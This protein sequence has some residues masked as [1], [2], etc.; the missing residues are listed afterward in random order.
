VATL[1]PAEELIVE[2]MPT[3]SENQ[4]GIFG[5]RLFDDAIHEWALVL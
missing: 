5:R 3:L 2:S 1:E 4:R